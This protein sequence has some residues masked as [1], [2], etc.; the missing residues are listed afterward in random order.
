MT[1]IAWAVARFKD[2]PLEYLDHRLVLGKT[3][4]D[5]V[6]SSEVYPRLV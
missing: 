3:G 2:N 1:S 5:P 6:S 4:S